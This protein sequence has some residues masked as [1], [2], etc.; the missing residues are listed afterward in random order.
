M[1]Q[2][3]DEM[4]TPFVQY[5]IDHDSGSRLTA[6]GLSDVAQKRQPNDPGVLGIGEVVGCLEHTPAGDWLLN[7]ASVPTLSETQATT[8]VALKAAQSKPLGRQRYHLLGISAFNPPIH[9]GKRVAVKGILVQ[10]SHDIRINVTSLQTIAN[11]CA[12]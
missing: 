1:N 6:T 2:S 12:Y 8:S 7:R 5:S 4:F 9:Q 11:N 3:W 10:D